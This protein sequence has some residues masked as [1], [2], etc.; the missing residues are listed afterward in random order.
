MRALTIGM[1]LGLGLATTSGAC[2]LEDADTSGPLEMLRARQQADVD[3][4][5]RA[6]CTG[7]YECGCEE[8]W[9]DF[10]DEPECL[11]FISHLLLGHLEQ[12]IDADLPYDD[13]CLT[14]HVELIEHLGCTTGPELALDVT[15][16]KLWEAAEQCRSYVGEI[17]LGQ[18]CRT[19][20]TGRGDDCGSGLSCHPDFSTCQDQAP[21]PEGELCDDA[22]E[23][24]CQAGT[25]CTENLNG[26]DP[27]RC[28]APSPIG[29]TCAGGWSCEL[30]GLCNFETRTCEPFLDVGAACL[31]VNDERCG[32]GRVCRAQRCEEQAA[33]GQPCSFVGC[34]LGLSCND[35]LD[36]CERV[37]GV[38][39][40]MQDRLP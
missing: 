8:D 18:P 28:L 37:P 29:S 36:V 39:C 9:P 34:G 27:A 11:D 25:H 31:G 12:G 14:A 4:L 30:D 21:I 23:R 32:P 26:V 20:P 40:G 33:E 17:E 35:E 38:V 2:V 6:F 19:L 15:A 10:D 22:D 3:E 5:A 7:Y 24:V 16:L 1:A 13:S